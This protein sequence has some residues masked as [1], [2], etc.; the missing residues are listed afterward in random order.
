M[1]LCAAQYEP[2]AGDIEKNIRTHMNLTN[3]AASQG[4]DLIIFPELSLTGYEPE[5]ARGLATDQDDPRLDVFQD[6]SDVQDISIGVGIPTATPT[7]PRISTIVFQPG[8][9]RQ[10][11]SKQQLHS[12]ELPFFT[13]GDQQI[14]IQVGSHALAFAICYESLQLDHAANAARLGADIYLASV[15]KHDRG[16]AQ[17]YVHYAAIARTYSMTVLMA[18][19]LGLCDDFIGAGQSAIWN[20]RGKLAGKLNHAREGII[21]IE[22]L[23]EA[24]CVL[25]YAPS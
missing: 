12:D 6:L 14:V 8:K 17:A 25:D 1:R 24:V 7:R 23:T 20:S 5:L 13:C 3:L 22:T 4:A 2:T 10:T 16:V 15:A 9:P 18:N 11:Y 21:M 19:C